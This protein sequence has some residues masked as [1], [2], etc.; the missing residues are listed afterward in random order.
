MQTLIK[1]LQ[2]LVQGVQ[3]SEGEVFCWSPAT[4]TISYQI[5]SQDSQIGRWSLLHETGHALLGHWD[6][7]SD[8]DLLL[9]EV[10]AWEKAKEIGK[11]V[12]ITIDEQH[13]QDCIDTY[14]DWLHQ[15]STC[16]RCSLVSLQVSSKQYHC[17]NC[18]SN[19][20]VTAERF[21]RPYR[22]TKTNT[23]K[24]LTKHNALTTTFL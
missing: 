19:W 17:H 3:F 8:I 13:I 22:L 9:I 7:V 11:N 14:R 15:R 12:A 5:G 20:Y 21:C 10:S 16:P 4:A 1:Q 2:S 24:P 18:G 6:F 23:K